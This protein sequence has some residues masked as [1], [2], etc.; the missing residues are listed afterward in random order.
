M[1]VEL[2]YDRDCPN[3]AT[4]RAQLLRAFAASN[5]QARWIEW[6]R[7]APESP[8]YARRYGSPTILV[9][10]KDVAGEPP[11][12]GAACCRL[13]TAAEAAI[14]GVPPVEVISNAIKADAISTPVSTAIDRSSGWKCSLATIPGVVFSFL[15]NL[16]CP[17]CWPAYAGLLSSLG[18]GFLIDAAY[19]VPLTALFLAL[20]LAALAF[21]ARNRRGY[22]PFA[23]G[24]LA[25][26]LVL[27][28]KF[29][30]SS[31]PIAYSGTGL[32]LAAS[33]WNA[34]PVRKGK[35]PACPACVSVAPSA[36]L[37]SEKEIVS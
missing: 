30:F 25:A 10:G 2:I 29:L 21:R 14:R 8:D 3:V 6:D 16:A 31:S 15:P 5:T 1:T 23:V 26:A 35:R 34:W 11:N 32:L 9:N 37:L 28:G 19:L 17:A 27:L 20:A 18:L 24:L 13:Y 22:G 33:I 4:A 7:N 12:D 36:V